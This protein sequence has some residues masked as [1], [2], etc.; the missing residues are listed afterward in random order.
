MAV[1]GAPDTNGND[2]ANALECATGVLHSIEQWNIE[3]RKAK[4]SDVAVGVGVHWG[5]VFCGAIGDAER[6]EFTVLGDTVN[7]AARLEQL[8]KEVGYPIVTSQ[9]IL[10]KAGMQSMSD[11][12]WISVG[13]SRIRGRKG[14]LPLFARP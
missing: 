4:Y 6:L 5:E 12:G 8:T 14:H 9:A 10:A 13:D 7:V 11:S 2:A 3:R 1:F